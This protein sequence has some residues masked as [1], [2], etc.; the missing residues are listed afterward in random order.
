[1]RD[2]SSDVCSSDLIGSLSHAFTIP[3]LI[4]FKFEATNLTLD[5][6][7][8]SNPAG[9]NNAFPQNYPGGNAW[10]GIYIGGVNVA[11]PASL[12]SGNSTISFNAS[13]VLLDK[14]GFTGDINPP[15]GILANGK[16]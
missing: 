4:G 9:A 3:E 11:L 5:H 2:W 15:A 10:T 13:H 1:S 16:L 12:K 14:N 6:S 7:F 8:S